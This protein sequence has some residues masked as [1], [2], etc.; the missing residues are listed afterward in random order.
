MLLSAKNAVRSSESLS[1]PINSELVANLICVGTLGREE[2][3]EDYEYTRF[4]NLIY[5][6]AVSLS[7]GN[8][9][10][11]EEYEFG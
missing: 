2:Q 8:F 3:V 4:T 10:N 5:F 9:D 11:R 1:F 6:I 7:L